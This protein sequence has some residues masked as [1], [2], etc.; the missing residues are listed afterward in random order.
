MSFGAAA[1]YQESPA[2]AE[3]VKG[4][5][6]PPVQSRLP[7]SPLVTTFKAPYVIGRHG[8]D[9]G[10]LVTRAQDVRLMVVFGYSRLVGYDAA[11]NLLPDIAQDIEIEDERIFTFRLRPGHKW[12]DGAPFTSEDFRYFWEDVVGDKELSPEGVPETLLLDG[13][14]PKVSFP[15]RHTVRYEWSKHNP[16]FLP[17]IAGPAPLYIFRPAHYLKQ[18]HARYAEERELMRQVALAKRRNWAALHQFRDNQYR[19]DNP[20]MPSLEPWVNTTRAPATRFVMQRN[21]Y[22]HRVDAEGRQLPYIDRVILNVADSKLIP[23]KVGSGESDLQA[24]NIYFNNFTFLRENEGRNNYRTHLWKTAKG[25]HV[26]LFPNL[27]HND[28]VWR[29]LFRDARFR[30]A[31][32]LAIDRPLINQALYYGLA[33]EA[34]NTVLPES[35]LYREAYANAFTIPNARAAARLLD[36]MGLT[37]R[38]KDKTRLLPDGRPIHIIVETAGEDTEQVDVLEL[39]R[40]DLAK[41]GVKLFTKP[42]QREVFRNRIF[43]GETLMSIW[44]GYENGVPTAAMSPQELAP[45]S[46][47]QLMW[48]KWGQHAETGGKAGEAPDDAGARELLSLNTAWRDANTLAER[49]TIW[50]RMLAIHA[51]QIY[52]IG[53]I[54]GVRQPVVVRKN[55][56]NV[57]TE[58]IYN[59]DPGAQLGVYR[60]DG[61]WFQRPG[62]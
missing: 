28:P 29:E 38:D 53:I 48:P 54:S 5:T 58:A 26:A 18:F 17:Q 13:E 27:N 32:S 16:Y 20:D 23:A 41:I 2:L 25:S 46:Q 34:Q 4:G 52:A 47:Q 24:R 12:S 60:P 55:L 1:K 37:A 19:Y 14:A 6:L 61:F 36:E 49:T 8:G 22:Y 21:P 62:G 45:T 56:R 50:H 33:L 39:V 15:D 11:F 59:W 30:R 57:P 43:A 44:T 7:E 42:S 40:D 3:L 51:E 31:L 10:M 9:W 35:P